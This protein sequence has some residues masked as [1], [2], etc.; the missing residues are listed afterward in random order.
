MTWTSLVLVNVDGLVREGRQ[1]EMALQ[2]CFPGKTMH[3]PLRGGERPPKN[4]WVGDIV[5]C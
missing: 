5:Q 1:L 2:F 4:L 3:M